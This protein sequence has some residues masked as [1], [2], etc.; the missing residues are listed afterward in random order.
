MTTPAS[1]VCISASSQKP[2]TQRERRFKPPFPC[3]ETR[4]QSSLARSPTTG[5]H[6]GKKWEIERPQVAESRRWPDC[7][8]VEER[9]RS[10]RSASVC[11][12]AR[13]AWG[14]RRIPWYPARLR[15]EF[16]PEKDL[17]FVGVEGF[18]DTEEWARGL[19]EESSLF[20]PDGPL[21]SVFWIP[22]EPACGCD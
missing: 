19:P 17:L 16:P 3:G 20:R 7:C 21:K 9:S 1:R 5:S 12:M 10:P 6:R 11:A 2:A 4:S 8:T 15:S 18:A 22:P 14:S 13:Q